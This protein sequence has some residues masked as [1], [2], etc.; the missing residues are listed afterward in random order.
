MI[1]L[2]PVVTMPNLSRVR[3][4]R[5]ESDD[6]SKVALVRFRFSN[7]AGT[8]FV[9]LVATVC[10]AP[11][12][13]MGLK[14]NPSPRAWDDI[15]VHEPGLELTGGYDALDAAIEAAAGREARLRAI[16]TW[17]LSS[18]LLNGFAGSVS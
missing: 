2:S 13:S 3:A 5:F 12:R 16:E 15:V 9:E 8:R 17:A 11:A 6:E 18:G 10:N 4:V 7:P 14:V 1:T